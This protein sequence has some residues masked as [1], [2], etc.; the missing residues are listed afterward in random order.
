MPALKEIQQ[1]CL[2]GELEYSFHATDRMA[3]RMISEQE[4]VEALHGLESLE[5]YPNDKY[6]ASM[7]VLGFTNIHRP[8]H[9]VLTIFERPLVKIITVYEPS[10]IE[11]EN[12]RIRKDT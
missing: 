6:G 1:Q 5:L 11:W 8:L 2:R 10:P 12:F 3:K 4:V 9:I 7:L